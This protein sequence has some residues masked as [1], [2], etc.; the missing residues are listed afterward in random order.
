MTIL[1]TVESVAF[2]EP[3]DEAMFEPPAPAAAP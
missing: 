1:T 2:D 3:I